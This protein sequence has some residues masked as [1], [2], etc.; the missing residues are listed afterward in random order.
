VVS[1]RGGRQLDGVIACLDALPEII[2][3]VD[4]RAEVL[5][6][7]GIRH[8]TDI[9]TA[10]AIGAKAVFIG[11]PVLWG[12]AVS[13]KTGVS[14]IIS[15]LKDELNTAMALSGCANLQDIDSTLLTLPRLLKHC[16]GRFN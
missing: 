5:L 15:L 12:L 8:G 13:G 3:A 16:L 1:N 6:D 7:G 11:R 2:A 9:L 4:S 10:L 14:E